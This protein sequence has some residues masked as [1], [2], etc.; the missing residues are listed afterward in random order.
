MTNAEAVQRQLAQVTSARSEAAV[1]VR[2]DGRLAVVNIGTSTVTIPCV[3]FYPPLPGMPVR[4]DWVNGAPAVTGPVKPL[5]P[6][7]RITATGTPRAT[8]LVDGVSYT[9]P[10]M[11]SYS[12][13]VGDDVVIN[14]NIPAIQGKLAAVDAPANPD[15]NGGGRAEPFSVT[16]R[17]ADS[18]RFQAGSGWWGKGPWASSS[19]VGIWTY[20][21]RVRD[22][23]A[24]ATITTVDV[25]L[26]LI[27]EVGFAAIGVHPHGSLPGGGPS[28]SSLV[29]LPLGQR[30]GWRRVP[31]EFGWYVADGNRG[32]GVVA[33]GGGGYTR[34]RGVDE[35]G[36]SGAL[37]ISGTR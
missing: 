30:S 34:W 36:L 10:V 28:I 27:S 2:M 32:V 17:A 26:P 19:N 25:Y 5:N 13:T 23:V 15:E 1:F 18:G 16:V 9:L 21:N 22:A 11:S 24:G 12:P 35:D 33:P 3:G 20:G 29:D 4:V 6:I 37:R 7:G 14:W 31:V 8:V